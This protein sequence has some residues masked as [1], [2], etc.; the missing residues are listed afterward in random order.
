MHVT[1]ESQL[2]TEIRLGIA[3]GGRPKVIVANLAKSGRYP[4]SELLI[5][6]LKSKHPEVIVREL[7]AAHDQAIQEEKCILLM[8]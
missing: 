3:L 8:M 7:E 2:L 1:M 4:A 6:L 5:G